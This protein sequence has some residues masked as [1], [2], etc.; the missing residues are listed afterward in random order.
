MNADKILPIDLYHAVSIANLTLESALK[1]IHVEAGQDHELLPLEPGT[2]AVICRGGK[3]E[4]KALGKEISIV[5]GQVFLASVEDVSEI[6]RFSETG[7]EGIVIYAGSDL[8]IN[9][10][11]LMFRTIT[12]D[13]LK[14]SGLYI[15]L[16]QSQIERMSDV[17]VKVVESL[18]RA[19]I[20]FLQQLIFC[21]GYLLLYLID[22]FT[23]FGPVI[24][25]LNQFSL[26]IHDRSLGLCKF[27][28][29]H[30]ISA[31]LKYS[32]IPA[33]IAPAKAGISFSK[34][35]S[36]EKDKN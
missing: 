35:N 32:S 8:L 20:F 7:F 10:Q 31:C 36:H 11:R 27:F 30:H 21:F 9:R 18:L 25:Q 12:P 5:A 2:L 29:V 13:E 17:R 16:M 6:S 23:S 22:F 33:A 28:T 24:L 3:F 34:R 1:V 19:L 26:F 15:Q 14:E 4:C